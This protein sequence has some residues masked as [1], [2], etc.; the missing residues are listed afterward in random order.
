MLTILLIVV[1]TIVAGLYAFWQYLLTLAPTW[2]ATMI[3]NNAISVDDFVGGPP[4]PSLAIKACFLNYLNLGKRIAR[5]DGYPLKT[6]AS[7]KVHG[8]IVTTRDESNPQSRKVLSKPPVVVGTIRMGF[9]HHRIAYAATSWGIGG[10]REI[11]FHDFLSIE[12][13]EAQ[14]IKDTDAMYSKGSRMASEVRICVLL[15]L[16]LYSFMVLLCWVS[17]YFLR[18]NSFIMLSLLL[19]H[20]IPYIYSAW[21]CS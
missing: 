9:G 5:K 7:D 2:Y 3:Q 8:L 15:P 13:E 21:G 16:F 18:C 20:I 17:N 14:M 10:E 4:D 19:L 6:V 12:S 11:W 1:V